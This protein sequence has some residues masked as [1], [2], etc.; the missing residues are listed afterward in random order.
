MIAVSKE[1]KCRIISV[2]GEAGKAWLDRLPTIITMCAEGWRLSIQ[3]PVTNL[4]YSFVAYVVTDN[5]TKAILKIGVPNPELATEIEALQTYR[6]RY[7]VKLLESGLELGALL[8]QRLMSGR[9]LSALEDDEAA[10]VIA[11]QLMRDLPLPEPPSHRFPTV[12]R[13]AL[14]FDRYRKRFDWG[15]GPLPKKMVEKA[16][17]LFKDLRTSSPEVKLLHGDLHH[18]NILSNGENEW[19]VI[20][21]KG[22][23]G[24]PAYEAARFQ[25]NPIPRFLGLENPQA[26]AERRSNILA[27]I[28]DTDRDRLLA[29]AFFDVMLGACWCIEDNGDDW[30]YFLSCAKILDTLTK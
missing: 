3:S 12:E 29:W 6:G 16:D 18:N 23:I 22:V 25:H 28:L 9:P 7:A 14:A 4:S 5:G 19:L 21:P 10:T 27:S 1:F 20:D 30:R 11:A 24:D 8:L 17:R 26:V 15:S 13:W 2:W